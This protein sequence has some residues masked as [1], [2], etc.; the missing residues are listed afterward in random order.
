MNDPLVSAQALIEAKSSVAYCELES[1]VA[2]LDL[3]RSTYY[4][5]NSVAAAI[6]TH[7][8]SPKTMPEVI[9]LVEASFDTNGHDISADITNLVH[10]L[11]AKDLVNV[12]EA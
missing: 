11:V 5:L 2:L 10:D 6:W 12:K 4:A 9:R 7:I 1:S 8:Q 3:D